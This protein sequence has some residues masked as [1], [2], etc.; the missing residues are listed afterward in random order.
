MDKNLLSISHVLHAARIPCYLASSKF[1][2]N[3][4]SARSILPRWINNDRKY[5][6]ELKILGL[7]N[8]ALIRSPSRL[9]FNRRLAQSNQRTPYPAANTAETDNL[10]V[11]HDLTFKW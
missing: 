2:V 8:R 9:R 7:A 4:Q 10:Q 6:A 11:E 5:T 1:L 3:P